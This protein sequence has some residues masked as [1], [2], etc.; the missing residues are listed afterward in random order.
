MSLEKIKEIYRDLSSEEAKRSLD[1]GLKEMYLL[2]KNLKQDSSEFIN[3]TI[4]YVAIF[5][6]C[7]EEKLLKEQE[8]K[9]Y[10]RKYFDNVKKIVIN[11]LK[12]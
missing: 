2:V 9:D 6:I 12:N 1:T 5:E 10:K 4:R 7:E 11:T 3:N 8:L